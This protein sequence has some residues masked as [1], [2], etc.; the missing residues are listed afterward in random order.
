MLSPNRL[1]RAAPRLTIAFA[2]SLVACAAGAQTYR[3]VGG[4]IVTGVM[5]LPY[6]FTPLPPGQHNLAAA[7]AMALTVPAGA[8]YATVCA[9]TAAAKYTT[10]GVTAPTPTVGQPLA[11]GACVSLSGAAVIANFRVVS[12]SGTLDV[13]YFQ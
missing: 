9:S 6:A 2:A 5:P 10:D 11:A 7:S 1:T 4:T 8:Q 13:E 12:P 3:D